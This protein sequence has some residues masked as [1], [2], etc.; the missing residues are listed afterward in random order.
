MGYILT[1]KGKKAL[2]DFRYQ[3]LES[4]RDKGNIQ[5][6]LLESVDSG[7]S[8]IDTLLGNLDLEWEW[9]DYR[10]VPVY[11]KQ[12]RLGSILGWFDELVRWDFIKEL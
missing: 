4:L 2:E 6:K 8:T 1:E 7:D 12:D 11:A 9:P 3:R 5:W 10:M